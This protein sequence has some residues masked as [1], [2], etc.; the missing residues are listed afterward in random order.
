MK[1]AD[2]PIWPILKLLSVSG[3]ALI[4]HPIIRC[5][6]MRETPHEPFHS[7][8]PKTLCLDDWRAHHDPISS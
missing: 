8:Q 7:M 6:T 1:E 3:E 4:E 2:G 5:F